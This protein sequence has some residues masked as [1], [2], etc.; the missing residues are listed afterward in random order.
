MGACS[1]YIV[2]PV[3]PF[4]E[5]HP[6]L[7]TTGLPILSAILEIQGDARGLIADC[8]RRLSPSLENTVCCVVM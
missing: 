4:R 1:H 2:I 8:L 3:P 5:N 6:A 7:R